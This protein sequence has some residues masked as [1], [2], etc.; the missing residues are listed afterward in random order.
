MLTLEAATNQ[1]TFWRLAV[2]LVA[3]SQVVIDRPRWSRHP[4]YPDFLYPL[5]Y[6]YLTPTASSDGNGIDVWLGSQDERQVSGAIV[7]IDGGKRD[8]EV[9]FLLGC[10]QAEAELALACHN[11]GA[12]AG[13]LLRRG[14][15]A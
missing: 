4:H 6:G 9:K 8:A 12:Q 10:T 2:D 11:H 3:T 13:I 1:E 7:T 14:Q 15:P 5:D